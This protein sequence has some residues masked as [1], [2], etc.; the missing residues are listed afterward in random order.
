MITVQTSTDSFLFVIY[1]KKNFQGNF[2]R[3]L[4]FKPRQTKPFESFYVKMLISKNIVFTLLYI[5]IWQKKKQNI[6]NRNDFERISIY[7]IECF[8]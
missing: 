1:L 4:T 2:E 3:S 6:V 8:F 7:Q 5:L